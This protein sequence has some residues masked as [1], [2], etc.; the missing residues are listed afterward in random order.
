[1]TEWPDAGAVID[2]C[3]HLAAAALSPG[4]SGNVS[5]RAGDAVLMTPTGSALSR[6]TAEQLARV[7]IG[8]TGAQVEAGSPSKELPLH[9]AVYAARPDVAAIVHLHSPA[10]TAI[11]CLPADDSGN[12]ALPP[13]TPYR[14]MRLGDV[15]LVPYAPPGSTALADGVAEAARRS[16]VML[17]AQHGPMVAAA[18][19]T[20][21]TDLAEELETAAQVSLLLTGRRPTTLSAAESAQLRGGRT[22]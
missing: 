9:L 19:L 2:A 12:A 11:A 1:V 5:V 8:A 3:R 4:S 22:T 15:P 20:A 7:R 17:L 16:P 10:A 21:A 6:V 14:V 13:L 18:T